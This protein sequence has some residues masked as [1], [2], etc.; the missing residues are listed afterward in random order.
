[1]EK[2]SGGLFKEEHGCSVKD[3][4]YEVLGGE[5]KEIGAQTK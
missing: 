5:R 4:W 2:K 3:V 1:L